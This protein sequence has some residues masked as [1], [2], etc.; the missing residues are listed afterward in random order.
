MPRAPASPAASGRRRRPPRPRPGLLRR[1][2]GTRLALL[3]ALLLATNPYFVRYGYTASTD[4]L[5]LALQAATL[6]LLLGGT[7]RRAAAAAGLVAALA[8]LT[9]YSAIT[10]LPVGL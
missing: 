4:A 9:R 5:A 6:A 8:F 2:G 1:R 7:G 10:L 3:T